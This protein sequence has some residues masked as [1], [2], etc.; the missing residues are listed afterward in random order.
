MKKFLLLLTIISLDLL[1]QQQPYL[2]SPANNET[3]VKSEK[4]VLKWF[5]I[6]EANSFQIQVSTDIAFSAADIVADQISTSESTV[7]SDLNQNSNYYWR[8]RINSSSAPWSDIWKFKTTGAARPVLLQQPENESNNLETAVVLFVWNSDSANASYNLQLSYDP[9]FADTIRNVFADNNFEELTNLEPGHLHFWRVKPF[10]ADGYPGEW[11]DVF[12]FKTMLGK[13]QLIFPSNYSSNNDTSIIFRWNKVSSAGIYDFQLALDKDFRQAILIADTSTVYNEIR[14]SSLSNDTTYYWRVKSRNTF[15]DTSNFSL[16]FE[17]K[18]KLHEPVLTEPENNSIN[19]DPDA[20]LKWTPTFQFHSYR[21]QI[22]KDSLFR[23]IVSDTYEDESS[24]I[25]SALEYNSEYYWRVNS[26]NNFGDTSSWSAK[27]K[28]TTKLK[29]PVILSH[30]K[31]TSILTGS[32]EF[33]WNNV[34]SA[35]TYNFEFAG[36]SSFKEIILSRISR[37]TIVTVSS[38][39]SGKTYFWKVR[40]LGRQN[41][42]SDWTEVHIINTTILSSNVSYI[43]YHLD[44]SN[45]LSD[46]LTEI[47]IFNSSQNEIV[48][49]GLFI[50]PNTLFSVTPQSE[51]LQASESGNIYIL[52]DTA[53]V[54]TGI[55]SGFMAIPFSYEGNAD[56][57]NI[58]L[59][60]KVSEAIG[61]SDVNELKF[62]STLSSVGRTKSISLFN[63]GN[64]PLKINN[65]SF[66]GDEHKAFKLLT[67]IETINPDDTVEIQVNFNPVKPDS[68]KAVLV[69]N[70]N[71][72]PKRNIAVN[73]IGLGK[74]GNFSGSTIA[75]FKQVESKIFKSV[76]DGK[77]KILIRNDGKYNIDYDV[78]FT[79]NYFRLINGERSKFKLKPGDTTS[80]TIQY[81]T[82][83]LDELNIDTL[84]INHNAA[85]EK[86][87]KIALQGLY[88]S[89]AV[90]NTIKAG[91]RFNG[92]SL[93]EALNSFIVP[94]GTSIQTNNFI[95][96][97]N[98]EDNIG[99]RIG[100]YKGG[101]GKKKQALPSSGGQLIIPFNEVNSNGLVL[102]GEIFTKGYQSQPID[103][104]IVFDFI[105][106]QV[107]EN[108]F[109]TADILVP[110][111]IPAE[112]ALK[113][114][115]NWV[116]FG[117]PFERVQSDS[118]FNDLG[119]L[120]K[121]EDGQWIV[122]GFDSDSYEYGLFTE[123]FIESRK[124]YFIAQSVMKQFNLAYRYNNTITTRKLTENIIEFKTGDWKPISSPYTFETE[125][126]TAAVLYRYDTEAK[127]FRLTN[128]M[129]PGEGYFLPP[130]IGRIKLKTFGEYYPSLFPKV[131]SDSDW[132][133]RVQTS[134][135]REKDEIFIAG[136]KNNVLNK[137]APSHFLYNKL[138]E[139][140]AH[141]ELYLQDS[142]RKKYYVARTN[143]EYYGKWDM[144]VESVSNNKFS[145]EL[146]VHGLPSGIKYL[147]TDENGRLINEQELLEIEKSQI[148]KLTLLIGTKE[149][150]R[151]MLDEIISSTPSEF[152]LEQNYPNPFNPLTT[153]E[154]TI[155]RNFDGGAYGV[156]VKLVIYDVLGRK[157]QTLIDEKQN[158]GTYSIKFDASKFSSGVYMYQLSTGNYRAIR[159]MVLVK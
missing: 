112:D 99:F 47:S 21:V 90:S 74:G 69:F 46:T 148:L 93:E 131:I 159:K 29:T 132:Y 100:Y 24:I 128:I 9:D 59:N 151:T 30:R 45:N 36:D 155:P 28:F 143:G 33:R 22:A 75:Q 51:V 153:I 123:K 157:L 64:I 10:N 135:G 110:E 17:F 91:I 146:E 60:I 67:E 129:R 113:A 115:V 82:P 94:S 15:G 127:A 25:V 80:I 121:M 120:N 84:V 41:S 83:N 66:E 154:Y 122:Y 55:V 124:A 133:I 137:S 107:A 19:I 49:S 149:Q 125:V 39:E 95:N 152:V 72:Y 26:R 65:V 98:D 20:E 77:Q 101:P 5:S 31:T 57:I 78:S 16:V 126:D 8:V 43:N 58:P 147:I 34:E 119:G 18:T 32:T 86:P 106:V 88:D 89:A 138:K 3:Y 87:L 158:P 108:N 13:P 63:N 48:L 139:P 81:M 156:N 4:L 61:G 114:D 37:D 54:D 23:E 68:N 134:A 27:Y 85:A 116:L 44:F 14:I 79:E 1:A 105:D 104:V 144:I 97:F 142:E 71:S 140:D 150:L 92:I 145:I 12:S 52:V 2:L 40:A 62:D 35:Q 70:T 103:S 7:I 73:L 141:L 6:D 111:S 136:Q 76:L 50:E 109:R 53:G 118:V 96:L 11:S 117:Y 56:T 130:E 102:I 38:L 42:L